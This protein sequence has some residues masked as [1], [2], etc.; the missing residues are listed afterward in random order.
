MMRPRFIK[1]NGTAI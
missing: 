1:P